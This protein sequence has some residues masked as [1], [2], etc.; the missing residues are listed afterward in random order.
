MFRWSWLS[1]TWHCLP[2]LLSLKPHW[3]KSKPA[4]DEGSRRYIRHPHACRKCK[5]LQLES[6]LTCQRRRSHTV[7]WTQATE[8]PSSQRWRKEA[9]KEKVRREGRI[10][11]PHVS[12]ALEKA[13]VRDNVNGECTRALQIEKWPH[14]RQRIPWE[15]IFTTFYIYFRAKQAWH[16]CFLIVIS[17]W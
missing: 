5:L 6:Q 17:T 16:W 7:H 8:M 11:P 12:R 9:F 4:L 1:I 2:W 10:K 14:Q 15:D 3:L 13:S